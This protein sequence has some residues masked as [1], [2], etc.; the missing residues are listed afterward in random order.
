MSSPQTQA[1]Q[2]AV[3][4]VA[5]LMEFDFTSIGGSAHVY[6]S[7]STEYENGSYQ[8]VDLI[9]TDGLIHTFNWTDF[10]WSGLRSDLTGG[11]AEP[12]LKIAALT[13]WENTSWANATSGFSLMDYRGLKVKRFRMFYETPT[14][15]TPQSY[16]VKS[17][18][19]LNEREISFTLTPSLGMENANKPSARKLEI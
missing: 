4:S 6:L 7:D 11:I 19:E 18:D 10:E 15:I 8:E 13:L 9:W 16:F 14:F 3:G 1:Q 17:V 5:N 12:K 2:L